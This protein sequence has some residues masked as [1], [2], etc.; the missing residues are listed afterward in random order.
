MR[1][2]IGDPIC[3]TNGQGI[4]FEGILASESRKG[5]IVEITKSEK[6]SKNWTGNLAMALAPT[7]NFG[8]IEWA[9][10][11]MIEM[12][13]DE[14]IPLDT[15]HSERKAWKMDRIRRISIAALKQSQ[16]YQL[17]TLHEPI[18][19]QDWVDKIRPDTEY[20]L[21]HCEEGK[22]LA[23]KDI[24][25][26][27]KSVCFCIGPEGD[28][29]TKEIR[30]ALEKDMTAISLGLNR[31]RTETAALKVATHFSVQNDL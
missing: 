9:I 28:F 23:L 30:L 24:L 18:R 31:L 13:I 22:K 25:V 16:Q 6:R 12:G 10:E 4:H 1:K 8:R 7:K 5:M 21:G 17:P 3:F 27:D 26:E 20:Y 14:I 19:F 29:S 11:R 15:D 2:R